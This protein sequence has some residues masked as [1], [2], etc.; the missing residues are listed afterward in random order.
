MSIC[1]TAC[2]G[3]R[4]L[5]GVSDEPPET[6]IREMIEEGFLESHYDFSGSR[7]TKKWNPCFAFVVFTDTN[8]K[9]YTGHNRRYTGK[10]FAAYLEAH[11]LGTVTASVRRTNPNHS[12][13][14]GVF[15]QVWV[16]A[17]D[18]KA[19]KVWAKDHMTREDSE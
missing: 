15:L 3:T 10:K 13:R 6:L 1:D 8:A 19:L 18:F 4:E 7:L 5:D 14:K 11:K 16:W 17:M 12:G 9:S 2:C